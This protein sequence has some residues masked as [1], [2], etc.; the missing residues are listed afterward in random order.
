MAR[1]WSDSGW[2]D[3]RCLIDSHTALK[4]DGKSLVGQL[5]NLQTFNSQLAG[6]QPDDCLRQAA[7]RSATRGPDRADTGIDQHWSHLC[8]TEARFS[9]AMGA[10]TPFA[11]RARNFW[12]RGTALLL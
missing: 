4:R 3:S 6:L 5:L 7:E 11:D 12:Q 10:A 8:G 2:T 9:L 1:A